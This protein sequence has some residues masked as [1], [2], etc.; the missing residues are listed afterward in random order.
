[1]VHSKSTS[2]RYESS[3]FGDVAYLDG[4][5]VDDPE[6]GRLAVF[7]VNRHPTEGLR[8]DVRIRGGR[9]MDSAQCVS[10]AGDLDRPVSN[11][12]NSPNALVPQSAT[13]PLTSRDELVVDLPALSWNVIVLTA[14][15][16]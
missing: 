15:A 6:A 12:A 9:P 10:L 3:T 8:V 1:V 11:S 13:V 5:A 7:A 16:M 14:G 4:L 2:S